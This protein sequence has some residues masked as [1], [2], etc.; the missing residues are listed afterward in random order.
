MGYAAVLRHAGFTV[1]ARWLSGDHDGR[2][3]GARYAQEDFEDV[4][5]ADVV[6]AFTEEPC[7]NKGRGGRHVELGLALAWGKR[8]VIVGPRENVFCWLPQVEQ[9]DLWEQAVVRRL[10]SCDSMTG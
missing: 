8:V 3:G 5:A 4:R 1:D 2:T 7:S 10:T 6:M 9:F